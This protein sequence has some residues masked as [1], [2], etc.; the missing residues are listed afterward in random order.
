MQPRLYSRQL[1]FDAKAPG[2]ASMAVAESDA[3]VNCAAMADA[4]LCEARRQ[5]ALAANVEVPVSL[6]QGVPRSAASRSRTCR[7]TRS[8]ARTKS[9]W[10]LTRT[11]PA[12]R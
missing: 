7:P 1:G 11:R 6:R 5:E 2:M 12:P 9:A 8:T 10:S 3:V 4:A